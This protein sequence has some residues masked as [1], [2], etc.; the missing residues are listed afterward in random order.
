MTNAMWE[1]YWLTR[2]IAI[3]SVLGPVTLLWLFGFVIV[4][5]IHYLCGCNIE[6]SDNERETAQK[7]LWVSRGLKLM[8]SGIAGFLIFGLDTFSP[9]IRMKLQ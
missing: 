1:L 6:R 7:K 5:G 3:N 9:Q 2:S 8:A 4:G